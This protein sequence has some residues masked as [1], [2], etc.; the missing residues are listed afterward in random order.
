[1]RIFQR[2]VFVFGMFWLLTQTVRH[3]YVRVEDRTSVLDKYEKTA[4]DDEVGNAKSLEELVTK[5]DPLRKQGDK[6]REEIE[7]AVKGLKDEARQDKNNE[8][9]KKYEKELADER[10]FR[11]GIENWESN[12]RT[13][14]ELRTFWFLG[15]VLCV[16][17]ATF[18]CMGTKWLGIA[19]IIPGFTEMVYWTSPSFRYGLNAELEFH[20]LLNNKI[21]FSLAALVIMIVFWQVGVRMEKKEDLKL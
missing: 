9:D 6:I 20:R 3:I 21:G 8:L 2:A 16:V 14:F 12:T 11:T 15:F 5:Y 7:Q 19:F 4:A 17:G 13:V 18:Y 1:M 10:K